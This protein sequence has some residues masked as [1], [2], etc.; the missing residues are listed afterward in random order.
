MA[1]ELVKGEKYDKRVDV[2]SLGCIIY[3]LLTGEPPFM[4]NNLEDT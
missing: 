1:P 2:W 4:K 3:I